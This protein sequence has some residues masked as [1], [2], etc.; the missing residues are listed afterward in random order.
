MNLSLY[1]NNF[2]NK[3][4]FTCTKPF[5]N[6]FKGTI[7]TGEDTFV[8]TTTITQHPFETYKR[9]FE[10]SDYQA[11]SKK[12]IEEI[13]TRFC[14]DDA[15]KIAKRDVKLAID[16]KK[17]LDKEYGDGNYI[18]ECIGTSPSTIA[19]VLEFMGIETHYIPISGFRAY[20]DERIKRTINTNT[21]GKSTYSNFLKS[22]GISK[23]Q[24]ENS[25]KVHLFYDYTATGNSLRV[26]KDVLKECFDIPIENENVKFKSFNGTLANIFYYPKDDDGYCTYV[27]NIT[28]TDCYKYIY[29]ELERSGAANYGGIPHLCFYELERIEQLQ[30]RVTDSSSKSYN[31]LVID[32]L[33]KL[34]L[35]KHNT[36]NEVS[37]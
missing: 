6:S 11:L 1:P 10:I 18:F 17:H 12:E 32:E 23:E 4:N 20:D 36:A 8:R 22:Q 16:I 2:I 9:K 14:S 27:E 35:L 7:T 3:L 33:N 13:K 24:I 25:D 15:K 29:E 28:D 37:L 34:G 5:Q 19:R 31:F 30:N 21:E 26:F